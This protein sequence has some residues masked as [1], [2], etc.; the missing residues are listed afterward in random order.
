[1]VE[2]EP[3]S[4]GARAK[5]GDALSWIAMNLFLF[6]GLWLVFVLAYGWLEWILFGSPGDPERTS[7]T[8]LAEVISA[9]L[10]VGAVF[11]LGAV[12]YLIV[13]LGAGRRRL[14]WQRRVIAIVLSPIIGLIV[15][16]WGPFSVAT[17]IYGLVFPILC[18]LVVRFPDGDTP[19][20]RVFAAP[21]NPVTS[22]TG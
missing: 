18:G 9:F 2:N 1:M 7:G 10:V 3:K 22:E 4:P 8:Q 21:E 13:L 6:A 5:V 19:G 11:L 17:L 15:W 12:L 20:H 16:L 14:G